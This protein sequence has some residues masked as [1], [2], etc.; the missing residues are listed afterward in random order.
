MATARK[1]RGGAQHND[2]GPDNF[3]VTAKAIVLVM[4][5]ARKEKGGAQQNDRG[6]DDNF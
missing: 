1:E 5:R 3:W 2:M 6:P 4:T